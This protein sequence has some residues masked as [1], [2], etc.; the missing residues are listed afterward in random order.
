MLLINFYHANRENIGTI[1]ISREQVKL[2]E[3]NKEELVIEFYDMEELY[4]SIRSMEEIK[5]K[6]KKYMLSETNIFELEVFVK[7]E[8]GEELEELFSKSGDTHGKWNNNDNIA[9]KSRPTI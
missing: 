4:F 5:E 1:F 6:V 7:K 3:V 8:L 9:R 2:I